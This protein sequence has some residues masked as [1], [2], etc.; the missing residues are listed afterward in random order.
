MDQH[1]DIWGNRSLTLNRLV[2]AVGK[3]S[4]I[5]V[6]GLLRLAIE[7]YFPF[8]VGVGDIDI[9]DKTGSYTIQEKKSPIRMCQ[10]E[11]PP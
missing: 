6:E 7:E 2:S 11:Y 10:C 4:A 8:R 3:T 1:S 5:G 9:E